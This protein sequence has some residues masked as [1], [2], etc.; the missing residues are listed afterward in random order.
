MFNLAACLPETQTHTGLV[1]SLFPGIS[2]QHTDLKNAFIALIS[3]FVFLTE[4]TTEACHSYPALERSLPAFFSSDSSVCPEKSSMNRRGFNPTHDTNH[5]QTAAIWKQ[6][7]SEF[8]GAFDSEPLGPLKILM[9]TFLC[10]DDPAVAVRRKYRS[11]NCD[12]DTTPPP[13]FVAAIAAI[14]PSTCLSLT[15]R[16]R[17]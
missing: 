5:S 1:A 16:F 2:D 9:L 17:M 3:C 4:V 12:E 13:H 14:L 8:S 6:K 10:N 15:A 11:E 7:E